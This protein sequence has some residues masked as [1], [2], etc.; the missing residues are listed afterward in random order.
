MNPTY[1]ATFLCRAN[2]TMGWGYACGG[3]FPR[4]AEEIALAQTHV[5]PPQG[6]NWTIKNDYTELHLVGGRDTLV[7]VK[8]PGISATN[9]PTVTNARVVV[10]SVSQPSVTI[11]TLTLSPPTTLPGTQDN[12]SRIATDRFWTTIPG[13]FIQPLSLIHI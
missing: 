4:G 2:D 11:T 1:P 12:D 7:M 8:F 10:S 6:A 13:R 9:A 3:A 5:M